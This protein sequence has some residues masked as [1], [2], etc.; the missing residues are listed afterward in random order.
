M[1]GR[2]S[3]WTP[4]KYICVSV[5]CSLGPLW[6]WTPQPR[7]TPW[8]RNSSLRAR[9]CK[10]PRIS[11][12]RYLFT[13]PAS[14]LAPGIYYRC[15]PKDR[16]NAADGFGAPVERFP[17]PLAGDEFR[18]CLALNQLIVTRGSSGSYLDL[19]SSWQRRKL[20]AGGIFSSS[21]S[22]SSNSQLLWFY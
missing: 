4:H 12:T 8:K 6:V 15:V 2:T 19:F 13:W 18:P 7:L 5:F 22:S 16:P 17:R 9:S 14:L 10:T 20:P 1:G 3:R 11:A 21:S